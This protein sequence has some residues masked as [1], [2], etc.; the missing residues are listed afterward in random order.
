MTTSPAPDVGKVLGDQDAASIGWSFIST[1]FEHFNNQVDKMYRLYTP[2]ALVSHAKFPGP[3]TRGEVLAA[4]GTEAIKERF[5]DDDCADRT[6]RIV[7][8]NAAFDVC[9]GSNILVVVYGEWAKGQSEFHQFTQ[10]IILKKAAKNEMVYSIANDVLRFLDWELK[11]AST[12]PETTLESKATVAVTAVDQE[13]KE[14]EA[15]ETKEESKE[16]KEET[17]EESK[18]ESTEEA[19]VEAKEEVAEAT[20]EATE[21][22]EVAAEAK[23]ES[24]EPKDEPK[25]E[26]KEE[27]KDEQDPQAEPQTEPSGPVSWAASLH[28]T[29]PATKPAAT[30]KPAA[31]KV[32][33]PAKNGSTTPQATTPTTQHTKGFKNEWFSVL[34]KGQGIH[35]IPEDTLKQFIVDNYGAVK[36]WKHHGPAIVCDFVSAESQKRALDDGRADVEDSYVAFEVKRKPKDK[37]QFD[38]RKTPAGNAKTGYNPG[39]PKKKM[40]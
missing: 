6:N 5:S 15:E 12:E 8:T 38:K 29:T 35:N 9:F 2:D 30:V 40:H 3:D 24:A 21:A 39:A 7:I 19:K 27:A 33:P 20:E 10:T 14:D 18:E 4:K 36:Y 23:E 34:V 22:K 37:P 25:E 1:Y 31:K 26:P 16:T 28:K 13:E 17:K 11:D 32:T